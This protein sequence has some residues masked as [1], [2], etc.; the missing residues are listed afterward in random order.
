MALSGPHGIAVVG[1]ARPHV[2][3]L[4]LGHADPTLGGGGGRRRSPGL[5]ATGLRAGR[6]RTGRRTEGR[7]RRGAVVAAAGRGEG[8]ER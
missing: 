6:G 7:G 2:P 5:P 1:T 8:G 4:V 3:A